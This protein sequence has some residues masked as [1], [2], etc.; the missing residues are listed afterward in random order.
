MVSDGWRHSAGYRDRSSGNRTQRETS[1]PHRRAGDAAVVAL[2]WRAG[3]P[4]TADV[5][6]Y[7]MRGEAARVD[8][9]THAA[10]IKHEEISGWMKAVTV[11]YPVKDHAEFRTLHEGDRITAMVYVPDLDYWI[12]GIHREAMPPRWRISNDSSC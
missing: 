6:R 7:V 8:S 11:E 9:Q 1:A 10:L 4:H 12:A 3:C 5:K 2:A